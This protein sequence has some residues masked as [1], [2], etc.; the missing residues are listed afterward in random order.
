MTQMKMEDLLTTK[1]C[2]IVGGYKNDKPIYCDAPATVQVNHTHKHLPYNRAEERLIP[3]Q[4]Q[5]CP[6]HAR[7]AEAEQRR[8]REIIK[9]EE[10]LEGVR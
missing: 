4:R 5:Y 6:E 10:Y 7:S 3:L 1:R 2:R 8:L 9:T